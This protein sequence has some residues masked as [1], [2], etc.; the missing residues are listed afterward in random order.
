MDTKVCREC[1]R[2]LPISEFNKRRTAKDGLQ[3]RCRDCFSAYNRRRYASN[4][5]KFKADVKKYREENPNNELETRLKTCKKN[6]TAKNAHRAVAAAIRAGVIERPNTCSGCGCSN[7]EHRIEAH[8]YDYG[9]P[10]N[11]IWLCTPCHRAL[12]ANRRM[13]E[14]KTPYG[15]RGKTTNRQEALI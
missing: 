13:H 8:H 5:E 1:G 15:K 4:R 14:G 2:E 3:D 9:D 12:D 11:V 7:T 10:L 6:P